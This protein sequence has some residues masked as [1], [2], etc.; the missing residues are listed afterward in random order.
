MNEKKLTSEWRKQK[1]SF[2]LFWGHKQERHKNLGTTENV[3][4]NDST[5]ISEHFSSPYKILSGEDNKII[6]APAQRLYHHDFET[7]RNVKQY[8]RENNKRTEE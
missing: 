1:R 2:I 7:W 6:L 4:E 3:N 8:K 5:Q